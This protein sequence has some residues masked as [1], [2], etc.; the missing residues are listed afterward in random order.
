MKMELTNFFIYFYLLFIAGCNQQRT[1]EKIV[2]IGEQPV[3]NCYYII[4]DQ[5]DTLNFKRRIRVKENTLSDTIIFGFGVLPPKYIGFVE[6]TILK[7]KNDVEVMLD[8]NYVNPPTNN[9][10]F[11]VYKNE[12]VNGKIVLELTLSDK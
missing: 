6:Y 7:D 5:S 3:K 11:N 2:E 4:D 10:C 12:K 9:F 8:L 1:I